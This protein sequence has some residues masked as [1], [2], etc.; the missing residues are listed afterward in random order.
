MKRRPRLVLVEWLDSA[1]SDRWQFSEDL[2][3]RAATCSSVGWLLK[4]TSSA[5]LVVPHVG[6]RDGRI[7]QGCGAMSIPRRAVIKMRGLR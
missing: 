3:A 6:D 7:E 1:R 2:V 4:E 5:I